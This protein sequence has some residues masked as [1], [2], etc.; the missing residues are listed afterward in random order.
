MS[1]KAEKPKAAAKEPSKKGGRFILIMIVVGCLV[2]F[3]GPTLLLCIGLLPTL[4]ALVTDTDPRKSAFATIGFMNV[5]G[6]LPF[7]VELWSK[8]QT[9]DVAFA[10][11]K[12]PTTWLVMLGSAG[13]GQLI[14]YA[15]P[16]A[17]TL[18]A[19]GRMESRLRVLREGLEQLQIVWGPD[20]ATSKPIDLLRRK[21]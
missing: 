19:V 17:M 1:N 14:L 15:V 18:L 7:V 21:E 20:V 6:V 12:Q 16:T 3:G 13:I 11:I 8:G 2:P 4:V 9:I 10:I 5:A